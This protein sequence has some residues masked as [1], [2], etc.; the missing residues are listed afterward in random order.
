VEDSS[1]DSKFLEWQEKSQTLITKRKEVNREII[2]EESIS[3]FLNDIDFKNSYLIVVQNGMQSEMELVLDGIFQREYGLHLNV[4][5][6]SP[7]GGPDDLL[8][9]SLLIRVINEDGEVPEEIS[10]DIKGYV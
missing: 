4:S 10:I 5:I 7:R 1:R 6:D 2:D 8:T 9:H 3:P